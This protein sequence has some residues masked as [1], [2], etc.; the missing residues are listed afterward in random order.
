MSPRQYEFVGAGVP[1]RG[2]LVAILNAFGV[3]PD[4]LTPLPRPSVCDPALNAGLFYATGLG[5]ID[6]V[7]PG[8]PS[9]PPRVQVLT[10]GEAAIRNATPGPRT[11]G[12]PVTYSLLERGLGYFSS[13]VALGPGPCIGPATGQ[14]LDFGGILLD[15]KLANVTMGPLSFKDDGASGVPVAG[16]IVASNDDGFVCG[17]EIDPNTDFPVGVIV[18]VASAPVEGSVWATGLLPPLGLILQTTG[19]ASNSPYTTGLPGM[20][21]GVDA[22]GLLTV[23]PYGDEPSVQRL[24]GAWTPT[25]QLAWYTTQLWLGQN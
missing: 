11:A 18:S 9:S 15:P 22:D 14:E 19:A 5:V 20:P 3:V 1:A 12:D 25:S 10:S 24:V 2:M 23:T 16:S 4:A 13:G 7:L 8:P 21:V 17:P 6:R